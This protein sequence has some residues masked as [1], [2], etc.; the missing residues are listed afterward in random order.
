MTESLHSKWTKEDLPKIMEKHKA[1]RGIGN[2]KPKWPVYKKPMSYSAKEIEAF[3]MKD[4]RIAFLS[5]FSS[6]CELKDKFDNDILQENA[7]EI[8]EALFSHYPFPSEDK[9]TEEGERVVKQED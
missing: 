8:T 6:L 5:I 9:F 7:F 3:N 2:Y 1:K 4:K